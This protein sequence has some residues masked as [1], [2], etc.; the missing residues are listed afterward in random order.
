MIQLSARAALLA[1]VLTGLAASAASAEDGHAI[2]AK[3]GS[4][5][6]G[7]EY[8]YSLNDRVGFRV[9]W[10]GSKIG[11]DAEESG[12]EYE[13]DLVWDSLSAAADFHPMR[14]SFRLTGGFLFSNDNRLEAVSRAQD[15]VTI[16]DTTYTAE[17]VG[18]LR[19]LV[20]FDSTAP[21]AGIGW[22]W[23]KR[24]RIGVS[25]DLGVLKQ[26]SPTVRL[27]ADGGLVSD[28]AFQSDITAE[29]AELTESLE[30][31]DMLPFGTLG[32]VFRF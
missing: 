6:L 15:N 30:D 31:V 19:G 7:L 12:I 29:E 13:F 23:S 21:F 32:L 16:G 8:T 2:S 20:A 5:G 14:G 11:F 9:G 17:E 10:N 18:R 22:D 25:L 26:G 4:L 24:R 3:A 1:A 28:P 27:F